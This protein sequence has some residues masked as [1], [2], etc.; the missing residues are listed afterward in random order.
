L[1]PTETH[2][3]LKRRKS[4]KRNLIGFLRENDIMLLFGIYQREECDGY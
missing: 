4:T 3:A 2:F 1:T